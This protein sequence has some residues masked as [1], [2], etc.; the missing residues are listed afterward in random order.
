[1][2][3]AEALD[4]MTDE[5][6]FEL[7]SVRSLR[8][9][10]PDCHSLVHVGMNS[11]GKTIRSPIDGFCLVPNSTPPRYVMVAATTTSSK[12]LKSKWLTEGKTTKP[13][14]ARQSKGPK[15]SKIL[16][17]EPG[18]VPKAILESSQVRADL[19][20]ATFVLYLATNRSIT[21]DLML[22]A[23]AAGKADGWEVRFLEQSRLRDFLDTT[24][25]GHWLRQ[26]HLGIDSDLISIS[27]LQDLSEKNISQY[28]NDIILFEHQFL[29]ETESE[30]R[31]HEELINPNFRLHLLI[32][33]SGVGKSTAALMLL[34]KHCALGKPGLWISAEML[35]RASSLN[36]ALEIALKS[37][38]P[39]LR[40]GTGQ[41]V[42]PQLRDDE[43]L[44]L[45]FD[46]INRSSSPINLLRKVVGWLRPLTEKKDGRD[47]LRNIRVICPLWQA[48]WASLQSSLESVGWI[49]SVTVKAF[50][51]V[52]SIKSLQSALPARSEHDLRQFASALHD[53]PILIGLFNSYF[54][55]RQ[56]EAS[57]AACSDVIGTFMRERLSEIASTL[58]EP[59][60][61]IES[62]L[63]KLATS[64]V[65]NRELRPL[66]NTVEAWFKDDRDGLQ[67]LKQLAVQG[68][69]ARIV[70]R[71][72]SLI[73]EFR[74]D[75]LMGHYVVDAIVELLKGTD[76][77]RQGVF[78][79]YFVPYLGQAVSA[80]RPTD[81][82]LGEITRE[83]PA[84]LVASLRYM[85]INHSEAPPAV[86]DA[87]RGWLIDSSRMAAEWQDSVRL[88]EEV[89]TPFTIALTTPRKSERAF[90]HARFR[91]GDVLSGALILCRE[92]FPRTHFVW[93]ETM[94]ADAISTSRTQFV[95][96]L[97]SLLTS[98]SI[99]PDMKEGG[100]LLAGYLGEP[101]LVREIVALWENSTVTG[102][103]RRDLL[104]CS[105]WAVLRS[106][107]GDLD[108]SVGILMREVN[109]LDDS[110][111]ENHHISERGGVLEELSHAGRHGYP[112]SVLQYLAKVATDED[113]RWTVMQILDH[114]D[115]PIAVASMVRALGFLEHRAHE[116][117][118]FN[119]YTSFWRE[120]WDGTRGRSTLSQESLATVRRLWEDR[121]ETSWVRSYAFSLWSRLVPDLSALRTAQPDD[122]YF[123]TAV[124]HRVEM[125]D[126]TATDAYLKIL[127]QKPFWIGELAHIWNPSLRP[128]LDG[129]L[130][131][132]KSSEM[133]VDSNED[134]A[135]SGVLRDIPTSDAEDILAQHWDY[136]KRRHHFVQ[137]ALY[138][139]TERT[140]ALAAEALQEWTGNEDPFEH[141]DRTFGFFTYG[142][143]DRLTLRHLQSLLPY[144][145][146]LSARVLEHMVEFC[147]RSGN[148]EFAITN[149]IPRARQ[150]L[151]DGSLLDENDVRILSH[152]LTEWFPT[153]EDHFRVL[154]DA[155]KDDRRTGYAL[156]HWIEGF[157]RRE[158][159]VPDLPEF[160]S[161]WWKR[162]GQ[163]HLRVAST[164][165][166]YW[167]ARKDLSYLEGVMA[168]HQDGK[169]INFSDIVYEVQRRTPI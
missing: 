43:P 9:L 163:G 126:L 90:W 20:S 49:R 158:E 124:W 12:S 84:S 106:A 132:L 33:D 48:H 42:F 133:S 139:A 129:R 103:A 4:G 130:K 32:G 146:R 22:E 99:S 141:V 157:G 112:S 91:N 66:W 81:A 102:K 3:T 134:Y 2:T 136:L 13:K 56:Q 119:P 114:V 140:R 131:Q 38:M 7:L 36:T 15:K 161:L 150:L 125:G 85:R 6:A 108:S 138:V 59:A 116:S 88:L 89:A 76:A 21:K 148:R 92:F 168:T 40:S 86:V 58:N 16:K 95:A 50:T 166:R 82:L 153:D 74:H 8:E 26:K 67:R 78:D 17:S 31:A 101:S 75:R 60:I 70:D 46:D 110:T 149:L 39:S 121:T 152:S 64:L 98:E 23:E 87:A 41:D 162:G 18:D 28:A 30:R 61:L 29:V 100:L 154:D 113:L 47:L 62:T 79:P 51:R 68:H 83:R 72:G 44:L 27:L 19:P 169:D 156:E 25:I 128:L 35:D 71:S 144:V 137:V 57:L 11:Q 5:S 14:S 117:G 160:L 77:K 10:E 73:W 143:S 111:S 93:L 34:K 24:S 115:H 151:S 165:I 52:E 104:L 80:L 109:S 37:Q 69:L 142:L 118:G 53:D 65:V 159:K 147:G 105:L 55:T 145:D 120:N 167:G 122:P 45:V 123:L 96:S 107:N 135:L 127:E 164:L 155:A 94:I 54:S 1:V 97:R 63:K